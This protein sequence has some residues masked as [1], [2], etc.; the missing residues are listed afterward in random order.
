MTR[1]RLWWAAPSPRRAPPSPR[2]AVRAATANFQVNTGSTLQSGST[3][4]TFNVPISVPAADVPLLTNNLSFETVDI[5]AGTLSSGNVTMNLL[6]TGSTAKMQYV[7]PGDFTVQLGA[8]LNFG[9]SVPVQVQPG[10]AITDSG[11]LGFGTGDTVTLAEDS[12]GV[13][14]AVL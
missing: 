6:G 13:L 4:D 10:V 2:P 14:G 9:P 5:D 7:F 8:T 1:A 3:N 12:P 11:T